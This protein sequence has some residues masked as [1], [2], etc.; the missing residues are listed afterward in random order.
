DFDEGLVDQLSFTGNTLPAGVYTLRIDAMLAG[1]PFQSSDDFVISAPL[2]LSLQL[3]GDGSSVSNAFP[4]FHWSGRAREYE[5]K[6][7]E[8]DPLVH[9]SFEEA[10]E[11][12]PMWRT[13][14]GSLD[15]FNMAPTTA[16][17]GDGFGARPLV[18]GRTYV[19][20]VEAV[21]ATTSG[22]DALSSPIWS[23]VYLPDGGTGYDNLDP[24]YQALL[25]FLNGFM[26]GQVGDLMALLEGLS[27]SGPI[28]LNG[29]PVDSATLMRIF[30]DIADG[31]LN[32]AGLRLE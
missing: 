10:I 28:L 14:V 23:F 1:Q 32:L 3:P 4:S 21:L 5:I 26:N 27:L 16:T 13:R 6:V 22:N 20:T 19:W 29:V 25:S 15:H 18:P 30:N 12:D 17:Y 2:S 7:A 8:Y 31:Q 11:G 24:G 9:G